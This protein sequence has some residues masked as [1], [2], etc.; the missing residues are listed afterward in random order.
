MELV[1]LS[2]I[3]NHRL[4]DSLG[5]VK[6]GFTVCIIQNSGQ[7][8][9]CNILK[10]WYAVR[11]YKGG[12][13][14]GV[15]YLISKYRGKYADF[16]GGSREELDTEIQDLESLK[17]N[18]EST[19]IEDEIQEEIDKLEG[20]ESEPQDIFEWWLV[21]SYLCEKL[22]ELG[23]PVIENEGIWGRCTTGQAIL[24]DY[25]ITVICAN[26]E[27]LEGQANSWA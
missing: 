24:L 4:F 17:L 7:V 13:V 22:A 10:C 19:E 1:S 16:V 18:A 23:H 27:I 21:S 11:P 8:S 9:A 2:N 5:P 14:F 3:T 15:G 25:A 26:M 20:L 6:S 12:G